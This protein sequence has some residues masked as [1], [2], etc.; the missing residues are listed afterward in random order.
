MHRLFS[1]MRRMKL[2]TAS[3]IF[4]SLVL[5]VSFF[6][7]LATQERIVRTSLDMEKRIFPS[8]NK[9]SVKGGWGV[10]FTGITT[11]PPFQS[12][13]EPWSGTSNEQLACDEDREIGASF[14]T[15]ILPLDSRFHRDAYNR[16]VHGDWL[17]LNRDCVLHAC[18]SAHM[19]SFPFPQYYD[20][21]SEVVILR[22]FLGSL[23]FTIDESSAD[24]ILVPAL[25]VTLTNYRRSYNP[26][27]TEG[28]RTGGSCEDALMLELEMAVKSSLKRNP[29]TKHLL[30]ATQD[31]DMN[32]QFIIDLT[33]DER[34]ITVTFGPGELVVPSL[35]SALSLQSSRWRGSN[36]KRDIFLLDNMGLAAHREDRVEAHKQLAAY[37]GE[38]KIVTSKD[39]NGNA[40]LPYAT[41][42]NSL[43][44]PCF[45]GDL[46]FT[47][48]FYDV[49]I[50][51]AIP[52][53]VRREF[54]G[55]G[56]SYYSQEETS[57]FGS[58]HERYGDPGRLPFPTID[59][60]YPDI[61]SLE[62]TYPDLVVEMSVETLY[63]GG[64]MSF[65]EAIPE[66]E[67]LRKRRNIE[68]IRNYFTYDLSGN[69]PDAFTLMLRNLKTL[70]L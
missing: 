9:P 30:L 3:L 51:G 10:W 64:M 32:H 54:E 48:R 41:M 53:V 26:R 44:V 20:H 67:I 46:P 21:T 19:N 60:S 35:N 5:V 28:C 24:L 40:I 4:L 16:Y 66:D 57:T 14:S 27:Y 55:Y 59:H 13:F 8:L 37:K 6:R 18:D 68:S 23:T 31:A 49:I 43:F 33:N 61:G 15:Y 69:N 2:K 45:Y 47:K 52:I 39:S 36:A 1:R 70:L 11:T 7:T 12:L 34:V 29:T 22:K 25:P 65:L 38:K 58:I 42:L 17:D 62:L 56:P 50:S 63:G